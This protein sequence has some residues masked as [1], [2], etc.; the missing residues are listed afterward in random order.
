MGKADVSIKQWLKNK[1][2]FADLF[3]GVVFDGR[4]VVLAKD[5]SEANGESDIIIADKNGK[6]K[7][8]QRYRDVLMKWKDGISLVVL[9]IESQE[10]IHYAMPVRSMLYDGLSYTEQMRDIWNGLDETDKTSMNSKEFFSRF[11][12]SDKLNPIITIVFY[13]GNED[14]DGATELYEMFDVNGDMVE[15]EILRQYVPNYKINI[16]DVANVENVDKFQTDLHIIF[17]MLK[18]RK[19][20]IQMR[21]YKDSH[22]EE[23]SH[24]DI[25]TAYVMKMLL[26]VNVLKDIE[27]YNDEEDVNMCK[28]FDDMLEEER[29]EGR[30]EG[31][32][33]GRVIQLLELVRDDVISLEEA[34]KRSKLSEK[35][36]EEYMVTVK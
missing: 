35:E 6:D 19:D 16:L 36:F 17:D 29:M 33:E 18:C 26:N 9:A 27:K 11:R 31:R 1:E 22:K 28:A 25:E 34:V 12:K 20:K 8:T 4:K 24:V 2:R 13:H 5:L 21:R 23:L 15:K 7:A 3:N 32:E 14:W 30:E 10:K